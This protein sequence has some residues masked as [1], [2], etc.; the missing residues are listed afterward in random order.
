MSFIRLIPTLLDGSLDISGM[1]H[2]RAVHSELLYGALI[3]FEYK[4]RGLTL[5]IG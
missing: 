2:V 5:E 1:F 4:T 3:P